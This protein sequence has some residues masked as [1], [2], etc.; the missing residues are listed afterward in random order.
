MLTDW[1]PILH[2]AKAEATKSYL[3]HKVK[4]EFMQ[5]NIILG[6]GVFIREG[7]FTEINNYSCNF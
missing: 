5:Y 6:Q 1:K 3:I 4:L 2:P 7:T